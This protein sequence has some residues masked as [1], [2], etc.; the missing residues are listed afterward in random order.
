MTGAG[1][2]LGG[3]QAS[4]LEAAAGAG[5]EAGAEA[6]AEEGAEAASEGSGDEYESEE[7]DGQRQ[8]QDEIQLLSMTTFISDSFI[9]KGRMLCSVCLL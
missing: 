8:K 6:E 9:S 1:S 3:E 5:A 2:A 7:R 4:G